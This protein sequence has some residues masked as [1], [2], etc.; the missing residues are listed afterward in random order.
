MLQVFKAI[1]RVADQDVTILV[2]GE[3]GSGKELVARALFEHSDRRDKPYM[4]VNC[5]AL[6]DQLLE[7]ELF[8]HEKGAFTGAD[9]RR[10]GKF[11]Q[12]DGG[13]IFM[14]E[15]GDMSPMVQAKVLRLL[16]EQLFERVGGN[17]SIKTNVRIIAATNR[18]LDQMVIDGGFREDLLYRLNGFTINLPPLRHRREDIV[19]LLE[20]FLRRS[21]ADM[22][23]HH[24]CGIAP[25][26]LELLLRYDW[27]G[28]VRQLQSVVRQSVLNTSGTVLGPD[29]LPSFVTE[30]DPAT[31]STELPPAYSGAT[32]IITAPPSQAATM[33]QPGNL[34]RF[35]PAD[36]ICFQS[37]ATCSLPEFIDQRMLAATNNLYAEALE[38]LERYLLARVLTATGG[39]QSKTAK[40][41]GITR[42]KVRDRIAAFEIQ[43]DRTVKVGKD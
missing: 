29:S 20:Y 3:S 15:I 1:G 7:S 33:L 6:P 30:L 28:N 27:P 16:Q 25:A 17:E 4:A 41:L 24:L 36:S 8:G 9:R 31:P 10:E 39:N 37:A 23:K 11:Q 18:N 22:R 14:D 12:C 26:A 34:D 40:I 2:R 13:T 42:G 19:P 35:D 21:R 32:G 38:E 5:A 43:M